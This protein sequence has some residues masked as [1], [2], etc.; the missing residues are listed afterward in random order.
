VTWPVVL[1]L[2]LGVVGWAFVVHAIVNALMLRR[3]ADVEASI[4][5]E[6]VSILMPVRN[7][8]RRVQ[9]SLRSV[10]TQQGLRDAE[11][12]VLDDEST[13]GTGDIARSVAGVAATVVKGTTPPSGWLGKTWACQQLAD[14][15]HGS[16]L[17]F[18][19][20]DV[21]LSPHAAAAAVRTMRAAGFD[22]VCPYPRQLPGCLLGLLTQPLLQWSWLTFLP[23]RVAESSPRPSLSA[24]NGQFFV[25]DAD[26]YRRAG[27]HAAVRG[28]VLEDIALARALKAVGCRGGIVDGSRIATCRMYDGN[29]DLVNGYAKSLWSAFGS[30]AGAGGVVLM[31]LVLFVLPWTLTPTTPWA[32]FAAAAG[33]AS[34]VVAAARTR[35]NVLLALLHPLAI[36]CFG[37]LAVVSVLR[38]RTGRTAWKG[39]PLP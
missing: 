36:V 8:A 3:T 31:M 35:G 39:R 38:H 5:D 26:A 32:W 19:D 22:F 9:A 24:A 14:A 20:A 28:E 1:S 23:L 18:V 2:S 10:L 27:G 7:E 30:T 4:G 13:D 25:V 37:V 6:R 17:A 11:I 16:A 12:I 29:R 15:A 21:T 33:P 34:R